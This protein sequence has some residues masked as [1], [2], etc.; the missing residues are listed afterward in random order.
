MRIPKTIREAVEQR[1]KLNEEIKTWFE[2]QGVDLYGMCTDEAY[3]CEREKVG[4]RRLS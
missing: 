4:G 3:I 2:K 1:N